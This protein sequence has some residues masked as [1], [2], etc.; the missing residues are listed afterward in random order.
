MS[1]LGLLNQTI[2]IYA[3]SSY[4]TEGREVM[5]SGTSIKCRFQQ[6]TKRKLL[7]NGNL[8]TIDAIVYV[9]STTSINT[10]DK[11]TFGSTNYKVFGKYAA[12]DGKG[13]TNHL[14]LELIRWLTT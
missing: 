2:T 13:Q 12:I 14:K 6:T 7:P 3:K 1:L 8:Q 11:V 5:G 10:D 9:P 4:N